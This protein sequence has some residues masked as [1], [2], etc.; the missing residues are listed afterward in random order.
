MMQLLVGEIID[1]VR[2]SVK[3]RKLPKALTTTEGEKS[4]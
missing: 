3:M 4:S 1:L 2:D